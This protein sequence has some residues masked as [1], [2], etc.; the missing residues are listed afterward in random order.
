[1]VGTGITTRGHLA[2]AAAATTSLLLAI[3]FGWS[4]TYP[5]RGI[6]QRA[7]AELLAGHLDLYGRLPEAQM[8]PLALLLAGGLPTGAYIVTL[9]VALYPL[10]YLALSTW[11]PDPNALDIVGAALVGA[12]W[13]RFP[14][15]GHADDVLVLAGGVIVAAARKREL[16]WL[17]T[18]GFVIAISAKPTA[19]LLLPL[20]FLVDRRAALWSIVWSA[21]VWFPFVFAD[22]RGFLAAGSGIA[23]VFPYSLPALLGAEPWSPYPWW[24]RP[25]QLLAGVAACWLVG[26]K[27]GFAAAVA[28]TLAVR[29]FFEPGTYP[30]YWQSITVACFFV[31]L[32]ARWRLP[33]AT[34]AGLVGW[35]VTLSY[36][37]TPMTGCTRLLLLIT[38]VA[39]AIASRG[40]SQRQTPAAVDATRWD[41]GSDVSP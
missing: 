34:I 12:V 30:L 36:A 22:P 39:L 14:I 1:M 32:S 28:A 31:D 17:A 18:V 20:V 23:P 35:M 6:A 5:D 38:V 29:A 8:G 3:E 16:S 10:L 24:V 2:C 7:G 27:I 26:R 41:L 15:T 33:W 13:H 11:R 4:V 37:L 40:P 21:V 9:S 25:A 19:L